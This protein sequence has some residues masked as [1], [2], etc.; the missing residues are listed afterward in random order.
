MDPK[1]DVG[2]LRVQ[3]TVSGV[4]PT[5][6]VERVCGVRLSV[7]GFW[8]PPPPTVTVKTDRFG[9]LKVHG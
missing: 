6:F 9:P 3:W 7:S 5:Q 8:K 1:R 4:E 2:V